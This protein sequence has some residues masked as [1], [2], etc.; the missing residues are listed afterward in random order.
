MANDRRHAQTHSQVWSKKPPHRQTDRGNQR[1]RPV[2]SYFNGGYAAAAARRHQIKTIP[3]RPFLQI[4]HFH[5]GQCNG[6]FSRLSNRAQQFMM[7]KENTYLWRPSWP[8]GAVVILLW[9]M[10][11]SP[12]MAEIQ[13]IRKEVAEE[14]A[15]Y[16]AEHFPDGRMPPKH[17]WSNQ[18]PLQQG[19][20]MSPEAPG[21]VGYGYYFYNNALLWTNSTVA[22]YYVDCANIAWA[23]HYFVLALSHVNVPGPTRNR[24]AHRV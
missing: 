13:D 21:G 17:D 20:A 3:N 19:A 22:D 14:S 12:L 9:L 7:D 4:L 18:R 16:R 11:P 15:R 23:E 24:V 2:F 1:Q 5:S 10:M 8:G 6:N